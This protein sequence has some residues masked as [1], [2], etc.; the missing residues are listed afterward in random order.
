MVQI[1]EVGNKGRY[2]VRRLEPGP[3]A[4]GGL[5]LA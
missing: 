2:G 5:E 3:L 1:A 4:D